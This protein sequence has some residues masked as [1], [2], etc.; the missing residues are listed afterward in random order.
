MI[1]LQWAQELEGFRMPKW[2]QVKSELFLQIVLIFIFWIYIGCTGLAAFC[3]CRF[4][5]L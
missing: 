2:A 1:W 3:Q 4:L 5:P